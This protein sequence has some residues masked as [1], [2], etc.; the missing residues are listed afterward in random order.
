MSASTGSRFEKAGTT[1]T[2][3]AY[4]GW[5]GAYSFNADGRRLAV[6]ALDLTYFPEQPALTGFADFS[7]AGSGT[8]EEPRYDVEISVSDLF[9]GDEGIGQMTAQ[10]ALRGLNVLYSFDVA[11]P[12][13]A[14]SGSGAVRAHRRRRDSR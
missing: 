7:A 2:G 4:V 9:V 11:S 1:I 3:A 6:D 5:D 8:F 13:L 14:A 12:R 10:V